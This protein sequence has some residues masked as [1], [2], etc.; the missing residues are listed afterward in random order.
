[1][2]GRLQSIT[3]N[4]RTTS[5]TYF[6]NQL[7]NITTP[8]QGLIQYGYDAAHRLVSITSQ[9]AK[10]DSNTANVQTAFTTLI[11]TISY[12]PLGGVKSYRQRRPRQ[13]KPHPRPARQHHHPRRH[14]QHQQRPTLQLRC[15]QPPDRLQC[16]HPR[17]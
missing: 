5:L 15:P 4:S 17:D 6:N 1:M 12:Q 8:D 11:D 3:V 13:Q 9:T 14:R 7:W 16:R 10:V 2:R